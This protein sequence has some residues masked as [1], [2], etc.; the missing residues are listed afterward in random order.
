MGGITTIIIN[1]DLDDHQFIK[2]SV[3]FL[4]YA[5]ENIRKYSTDVQ[6]LVLTHCLVQI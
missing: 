3:E 2:K 4:L 6:D 1:T 5:M